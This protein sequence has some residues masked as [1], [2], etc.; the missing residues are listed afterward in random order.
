VAP[1]RDTTPATPRPDPEAARRA[2]AAELTAAIDRLVGAIN[3]Q[4]VGVVTGLYSPMPAEA[5][6]RDRFVSFV[7]EFTPSA[8][9]AGAEPPQLTETGAAAGFTLQFRW[10]GNFGVERR[11][12][13]R[14][15]AALRRDGD[16]W[17]FAGVRLLENFP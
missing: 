4:Q 14:F 9:R 17:V 15:D 12:T 1:P 13:A 3:G 11:Q 8:A 6:R 10:R 16:R 7:R 2:A 5:R